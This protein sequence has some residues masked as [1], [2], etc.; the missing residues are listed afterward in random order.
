M[1][2][3][4]DVSEV[5]ET[6]D[7]VA[8]AE[9]SADSSVE[10]ILEY[11]HS[12]DKADESEESP[13]SETEQDD[14][15]GEVDNTQ[16]DDV[17]QSEESSDKEEG[18]PI[19]YTRFKEK[20]D[21]LSAVEQELEEARGQ[22]QQTQDVLKD[23]EVL[24]LALK[25]RGYTEDAIQKYFMDNQIEAPKKLTQ[26]E[27]D[28]NTVDGWQGFIKDEISKAQQ[29]ITQQLSMQQMQQRQVQ[30]EQWHKEQESSAREVSEQLGLEFGEIGRDEGNPSTAVGKMWNYLQN[31]PDDKTLGYSKI[32]KLATSG[33]AYKQA[34]QAGVKKEKERQNKLKASAME[35][36]SNVTTEDVPNAD[37]SVEKILEFRNRTEK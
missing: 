4:K 19:P 27:Y 36:E 26:G 31:N 28:F 21:R 17:G 29:P 13:S 32:L 2:D 7:A 3:E 14:T 5:V 12:Q 8:V 33:Q 11:A 18:N 30:Q 16:S 6:D 15:S 24:E 37:W 1:L 35:S 20:V 9:P 10:E 25:K 22:Y 34:E 23:P